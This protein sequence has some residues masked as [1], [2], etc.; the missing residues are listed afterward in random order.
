MLNCV[1][2]TVCVCLGWGVLE[3]GVFKHMITKPLENISSLPHQNHKLDGFCVENKIQL[4]II[5]YY[6]N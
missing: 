4:Q 6:T 1:F 3:E 5:Q 2:V